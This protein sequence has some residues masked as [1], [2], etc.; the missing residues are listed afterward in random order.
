MTSGSGMGECC[1]G[2]CQQDSGVGEFCDGNCYQILVWENCL[3]VRV[4]RFWY[5]T[6]L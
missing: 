4:I 3:M 1:D 2:K 5:G 6:I